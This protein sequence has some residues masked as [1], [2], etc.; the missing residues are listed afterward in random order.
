M[1]TASHSSQLASQQL[2]NMLR[3]IDASG[4]SR[5]SSPPAHCLWLCVMDGSWLRYLWGSAVNR[6]K[7]LRY[8]FCSWS[9]FV[10]V[11]WSWVGAR[12]ATICF[13]IVLIISQVMITIYR[14]TLWPAYC[15]T[16]ICPAWL[17]DIP[18]MQLCVALYPQ[19]VTRLVF[20]VPLHAEVCCFW[21]I[22]DATMVVA[23]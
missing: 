5:H 2:A 17:W 23:W 20:V 13:S 12:A 3:L 7:Y 15:S 19:W 11:K 6:Q 10:I 18:T 16:M 1:C 4:G 22:A 14:Y 8:P 21:C 9:Y